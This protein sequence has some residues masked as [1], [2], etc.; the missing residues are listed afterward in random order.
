[1]G[2]E[3]VELVMPQARVKGMH[4]EDTEHSERRWKREY[5]EPGWRHGFRVVVLD[6]AACDHCL[7][8]TDIDVRDKQPGTQLRRPVPER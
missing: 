6:A 5:N 8:R 2:S 7:V 1:M 3:V 4:H